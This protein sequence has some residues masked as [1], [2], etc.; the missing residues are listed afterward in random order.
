MQPSFPLS[1]DA[2]PLPRLVLERIPFPMH[3]YRTDGL[4]VA[5]NTAAL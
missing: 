2:L 5:A 1:D 4:T 3:I